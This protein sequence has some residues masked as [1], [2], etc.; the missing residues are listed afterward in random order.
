M[1]NVSLVGRI[2]KD[3]EL[4][5]TKN[6]DSVC[7]FTLAIRRTDTITD[8]PVC[9]AFGKTADIMDQFVRKGDRI[10]ITG[11]IQTSSYEDA[12]K[13][14]HYLTE[15]YVNNIE[16]LQDKNEST[17]SQPQQQKPSFNEKKH[18]DEEDFNTGPLL[19]ISSDDLPF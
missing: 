18:D 7:R 5:K 10:G 6:G 8:F 17:K 16:F 1:N 12:D 14:K 9:N 3:L 11:R 13:K 4:R 19:D 2:T 15:V